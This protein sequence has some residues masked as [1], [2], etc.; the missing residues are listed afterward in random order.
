MVPDHCVY[1]EDYRKY[2]VIPLF[3]SVAQA[4]AKEKVVR[5]NMATLRVSVSL[6]LIT[7]SYL[8]FHAPK[9]LVTKAPSANLPAMLVAELLP[10]V[11]NLAAR[12]WS[13]EDILEDVNFLRDELKARFESLTCVPHLPW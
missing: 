6:Y 1:S 9:N 12:K 13:D 7:T 3:I 8:C 10:F 4:A 11:K 5:V 2:D